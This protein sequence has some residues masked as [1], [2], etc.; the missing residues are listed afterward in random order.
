MLMTLTIEALVIVAVIDKQ[1]GVLLFGN[2]FFFC[3]LV[4]D[5][6]PVFL[7]L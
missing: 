2:A 1:I 4:I 7:L 5:C 6:G 3:I